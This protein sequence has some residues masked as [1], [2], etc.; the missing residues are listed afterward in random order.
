MNNPFAALAR[1]LQFAERAVPA[2]W[3]LALRYQ[4]QRITGGL[5]PEMRVLDRLLASGGVAVDIGANAGIYA[6][7]L[8]RHAAAVH[9]FEPL[10]EFCDYIRTRR[11]ERIVVHHCALADAAGELRLFVPRI[12]GRP[13]WTRASLAPPAGDSDTRLVPVRTLDSYGLER[14]DFIKVDV[15]GAE[16]AALRGARATLERHHPNLL[17]EIDRDRHTR[18]SFDRL[19]DWLSELGYRPHV[20]AGDE[21]RPSEDPWRDAGSHFNFIFPGPGRGVGGG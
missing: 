21:I 7:A 2:R 1:R 9:A 17:V 16:A 6:H 5:E 20:L 3:R 19:L 18:Q 14:V 11:S 8:A 15:E 12:A 10:Q 13:V 4:V